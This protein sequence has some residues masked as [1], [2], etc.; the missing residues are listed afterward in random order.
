M[1][2]HRVVPE[3]EYRQ[4]VRCKDELMR[5]SSVVTNDAFRDPGIEAPAHFPA[6]G[7]ILGGCT[8]VPTAKYQRYQSIA[9]EWVKI[10]DAYTFNMVNVQ[11]LRTTYLKYLDGQMSERDFFSHIVNIGERCAARNPGIEVAI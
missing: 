8:L 10:K 1:E 9:R 6:D 7:S 3:S 5:L 2:S 11:G 4:L